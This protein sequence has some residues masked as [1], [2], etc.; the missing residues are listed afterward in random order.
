MNALNI[1]NNDEGGQSSNECGYL[2]LISGPMYS[3]KT[4]RLLNLYKQFK[5]CG[6]EILTLNHSDD[7]TRYSATHLS[8]HDLITVPCTMTDSLN[9]I[10][11]LTDKEPIINN[12]NRISEEEFKKV[13]V[14]LI[15]EIQFFKE[16]ALE[17][18][19]CAVDKYNKHV[20]V[21]GLDGDFQRNK[22]GSWMEYLLPLCDNHIKLHSYCSECKVKKAIFT[23]RITRE[24][25]QKIIGI[26]CYVPLCR[27]CYIKINDVSS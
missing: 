20:Y 13:R 1:S 6:I 18:I 2:E 24:M 5:F 8:S 27:R 26:D 25:A 19:K 22:F 10:I 23:H 12:N 14:I 17:W 15:N 4:S 21:C 16:E 11:N 9:S 7:S 3:G